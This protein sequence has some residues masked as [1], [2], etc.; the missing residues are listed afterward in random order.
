MVKPFDWY[1]RR[2]KVALYVR[3]APEEEAPTV[4]YQRKA[5]RLLTEERGW[6]AEALYLDEGFSVLRTDDRPQRRTLMRHMRRYDA[7]VV[8]RLDRIARDTDELLDLLVR[9][10]FKRCALITHDEGID[11]TTPVGR[12][13]YDFAA[14]VQH[15]NTH[16]TAERARVGAIGAK[17]RGVKLGRP[18]GRL[19]PAQ[20][21]QAYRK[22]GSYPKVAEKLKIAVGTAYARV[23]EGLEEEAAAAAERAEM[24][25]WTEP[26]PAP[27]GTLPQ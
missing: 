7:I 26:D 19:T 21:L 20:V 3:A 25:R 10:R 15:M 4:G 23:K 6:T 14:S 18:A 5:L 13:L 8:L 2:V 16:L 17:K 12:G 1:A 24:D 22:L 27:E 9:C 11:T